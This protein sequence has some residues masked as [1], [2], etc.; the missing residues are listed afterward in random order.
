M[1]PKM[2][3]A[4]QAYRIGVTIGQG[5]ADITRIEIVA[6]VYTRTMDALDEACRLQGPFANDVLEL[7]A[8]CG[9]FAADYERGWWDGLRARCSEIIERLNTHSSARLPEPVAMADTGWDGD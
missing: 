2:R 9:A 8:D 4:D 3:S 5:T 1:K 7:R 6:A